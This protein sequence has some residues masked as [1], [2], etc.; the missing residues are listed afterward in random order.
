MGQQ[1]KRV[2]SVK[3][4]PSVYPGA[5]FTESSIRWLIHNRKKNGFDMCMIRLGRK[6]LIDL[7]K[8]EEWIDGGGD[9]Y[10]KPA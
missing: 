7:D 8:F 1:E 4:F 6:I 2:V 9:N 5:D 10:Q 3:N